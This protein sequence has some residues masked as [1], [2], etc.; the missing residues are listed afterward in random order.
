M[1]LRVLFLWNL[2]VMCGTP[3]LLRAQQGC[4]VWDKRFGGS[5]N[6]GASASSSVPAVGG[7]YF[8]DGYST[9]TGING[10]HS[11]TGQGSFDYWVVRVDENGT[12]LWDRRFGG[13]GSDILLCILASADGGCLLGGRS[14]SGISGDRTEDSRGQDDYWIVKVDA[15]GNKQWDKR[16]GSIYQEYLYAMLQASDGGYYLI[17][18]S[19]SYSAPGGDK[20]QA[21]GQGSET[22]IVRTD[23]GGVKLWDR[24]FH[25]TAGTLTPSSALMETNGD[26]VITAQVT[27]NN[28][29]VDVSQSTRGGTDCWVV[30]MTASGTKLWDHRFGGPGDDH[31]LRICKANDGGYWLAARSSS[32][33]G[34]EHSQS[35]QGGTDFWLL[36]LGAAGDLSWERRFGGSAA[37]QPNALMPM[38]D[39]GVIVAGS[40]ASP[41]DGDVSLPAVGGSYDMWIVKV[42]STGNKVWDARYGGAGTEECKD[43]LTMADGAQLYVGHTTSNIGGDVSEVSRG[44]YDL[45]MIKVNGASATA[46]YADADSDGLGDPAKPMLA[47]SGAQQVAPNTLDNCPNIAGQIGST[48]NDGNACT[49]NDVINASCQCAG[50]ISPDSDGD[51]VCDALDTC[52]GIA[53]TQGGSCN[54]GNASTINDNVG[55][56][57]VCAGVYAPCMTWDARF[58]GSGNDNF[59]S[60]IRTADGGYLASGYS[61]SAAGGDKS[62]SAQGGSDY[63]VVKLNAAGTKEWDKRFG[64]GSNDYLTAMMATADGNYLLG[65]YTA[66][67][68]GGDKTEG[69]QGLSDYWIVKINASGTKLWDKRFGGSGEDQLSALALAPDGGYVLVGNSASGISGDRSQD[70]RGLLDHW[71]LKVDANGAKLWDKRFGGAA[72]DRVND[73]LALSDG[74]LLAGPSASGQEGDRT[75]SSQ[76]GDDLW[77]VK[78][79]L[80]GTKLWDKRYGGTAADGADA[81]LA[82]ADASIY[83]ACS[84]GSG[85]G[86]D[87]TEASRGGDDYWVLR[88]TNDGSKVWDRRF[89]TSAADNTKRVRGTANGVLITGCSY[90]GVDGDRTEASRGGRD[91][92]LVRVYGN[93]S[94]AMDKRFG[95]AL[96]ED[97]GD[98]V[99]TPDNGYLVAARSW[100]T[101]GGDRS[102]LTRGGTDYW[103]IKNT[104]GAQGTWY[105]DADGDGYGN[106]STSTSACSLPAGY[107]SLTG[108]CD[109]NNATAYPGSSCSDGNNCTTGDVYNANCQCAGTVSPDSDGDGVCNAMDGCPN[110]AAKTA[111]GTCGCGNLEP[112]T[113]CNDNN[114]NTGNDA[115]NANCQC[116]GLVLD[117]ANVPGG[118]AAP[119]QPCEDNDPWTPSSAYDASC[120]C[121]GV[122]TVCKRYDKRYGTTSSDDLQVLIATNDGGALVA[123]GAGG[124]SGDVHATPRGGTDYFV[125]RSNAGGQIVWQGMFGGSGTDIPYAAVATSDGGFLIGG[126]SA[127]GIGGDR[128][129]A[130]QGGTDYWVIRLDGNG[131]KLW[132]KRY[133]G[134]GNDALKVIAATTDGGFILMGE[135]TSSASGDKTSARCDPYSDDLWVL[136]IGANG[137]VLWQIAQGGVFNERARSINVA[138]DGSI[139]LGATT[140]SDL[141]C[142]ITQAKYDAGGALYTGDYWICKLTSAGAKV[143]DKRYG[144]NNGDELAKA[145]WMSDGGAILIG[146]S[147]STVSGVRTAPMIGS[148][149]V[150]VVKVDANGTK[151][152]DRAFG[153]N[154]IQTVADAVAVPNAGW[155][156]MC[157]ANAPVGGDVSTAPRGGF[158]YWMLR[159]GSNGRRS[160]DLRYGSSSDDYAR[161]IA[162]LSDGYPLLG[163]IS[164]GGIDGDK[165][166]PAWGSSD[167]WLVKPDGG[168]VFY[169]DQDGDGFGSASQTILTC[170]APAG[171]VANTLDCN[172]NDA[173][174]HPGAPCDDGIAGN[175]PSAYTVNCQCVPQP[176]MCR[177]WDKRSGSTVSDAAVDVIATSDGGYLMGGWTTGGIGGDKS[178]DGR[179][180]E[181]YWVVKLDVNGTVQWNKRYGGNGMEI[182]TCLL[183][184]ND[185][186]YLIGGYT[187]FTSAGG[188]MTSG[189][190]GNTDF[191]VIK[192]DATGTKQWDRHYGGYDLDWLQ[193][194]VIAPDGGYLLAG[195]TWSSDGQVTSTSRGMN[196]YWVIK[197]DDSG[198]KQWD[199]RFGSTGDD[200]LYKVVN[201]SDGGYALAGES[202]GNA[203][204]EKSE[205]GRGQTDIWVI[206]ISSTGQLLWD[207]TLGGT[208]YE[209]G[210]GLAAS[211]DGG[212]AVGSRSLS[213]ISGDRT[214]PLHADGDDAWVVRL[215]GAGSILWDRAF[216]S[217]GTDNLWD[218][219]SAS[220]GGFYL[221][222]GAID[223][224]GDCTVNTNGWHLD[225]CVMKLD[226]NGVKQWDRGYMTSS[227]TD[228]KAMCA[229]SNGLAMVAESYASI[230]YD[231]SENSRG[232]SDYWV[233]A[234]R[235]GQETE[236]YKDFDGDGYGGVPVYQSQIAHA[237]SAPAGF[238]LAND[239][240]DSNASMYPGGVC[241]D[242]NSATTLDHYNA[243][244]TC[245]GT[246]FSVRV[247]PKV[248]L[249][250]PFDATTNLMSDALRTAG[251]IPSTEPFT[252]IGYIH[253]GGGGG[254]ARYPGVLNVTGNN[255]IVDWVVVELRNNSTPSTIMATRSALLQRDGDVVD[256]DGVSAVGFNVAAGTYKVAVRH[257]NHLGVM[258]LSGLAMTSNPIAVDL[259]TATTAVYGTNARRSNGTKL[260]LWPGDA[261]RDGTVKYT[262]TSNDRDPIIVAI[263]GNSPNNTVTGYRSEDVNLDG[264]VKYTGLGNDRDVILQAIGGTTPTN[265]IQQQLP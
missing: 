29:S 16:F 32:G 153:G 252:G 123:M 44:G 236:W 49:T 116:T 218:M 41:G 94:L 129:Q 262:G 193:D 67:G 88:C 95:S 100:G 172:D 103:L 181:D 99:L 175:D 197:V 104:P 196:D 73:V 176:G 239:C 27:A 76:G 89:G 52:P 158:D 144:G 17:G 7:G 80:N 25:A 10:D 9:T 216:G 150:W 63:W 23:A 238:A 22:W 219:E 242:G 12:K 40:T 139:L 224:N 126:S 220:D 264:V 15:N 119:G 162:I 265:T 109:Y 97:D 156:V 231:R 240:N 46:Q 82:T 157:S 188:D 28:A 111:P 253:T 37:E 39:G 244:C 69:T 98:L 250:G 256:V 178:E 246:S 36:K 152:W 62:Q 122:P 221:G 138:T 229:T 179:G 110:D 263:G 18:Q 145:F 115:I 125:F 75:Q 235:S 211:N 5:G 64:S 205:N 217:T 118:S 137:D 13:S 200:L 106:S 143:W 101:F 169:R 72:D 85:I 149:D 226:A 33:I 6:E 185:G 173:T 54:D 56:D 105:A 43:I 195:L 140:D 70:S 20:T 170:T 208:G 184:A 187:Y 213:G 87:R 233:V 30:R 135:S 251:S 90:G 84:S 124:N 259:T 180:A 210:Y 168:R 234:L 186:G 212:V 45:W 171:Y 31:P 14:D 120:G 155:M 148:T 130:S 249:D 79:D 59:R 134:S 2:M 93:G 223:G 92:W 261:L 255:A 26:V 113:L 141:G 215:D 165:S 161:K 258:T 207:R 24:I 232:Y 60:V 182:L 198:A 131:N 204:Y 65:G 209:A 228:F 47:C 177:Q 142:T 237:C 192:V 121:A 166:V 58:G 51:G 136:K 159:L 243:A 102:W 245:S 42:S 241:N 147:R 34:S 127:S 227:Q 8:I 117:C 19:N 260:T 77:M 3:G 146:S 1:R 167:I 81:T 21:G 128:T 257:R 66:G 57:C 206:K 35:L 48:C 11:Q 254:E 194:M 133:G 68:I 201:T 190:Y 174:I 189:H 248:F 50:T 38:S 160:W 108:D 83:V 222:L 214:C 230:G 107:V 86:G 247:A 114:D 164:D 225:E 74:Y 203:G 53:G 4:K 132:D 91:I 61:S 154:G 163:G 55:S 199:K 183:Q 151:Q 96:D 112:G 191:W 202:N 78:T 71:M